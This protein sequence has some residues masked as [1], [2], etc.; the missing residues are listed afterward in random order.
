MRNLFVI[1]LLCPFVA[2]AQVGYRA[3]ILV[4]SSDEE[5]L[6]KVGAYLSN[7]TIPLE[8]RNVKTCSPNKLTTLAFGLE[9][10][11]FSKSNVNVVFDVK[12]FKPDGSILF[13]V[14]N[15]TK[16]RALIPS[17]QLAMGGDKMDLALEDSDLE[18][19]YVIQ[20]L[21]KDLIS[22]RNAQTQEKITYNKNGASKSLTGASANTFKADQDFAIWMTTYYLHP[23]PELV[24]DSINYF[25]NS[26][27]A[28]SNSH[29]PTCCFWA[30]LFRKDSALMKKCFEYFDSNGN[31]RTRSLFVEILALTMT[32]ESKQLT[33]EA[34]KK[35]FSNEL[36]AVEKAI[37]DMMI[38]SSPLEI[39]DQL[40]VGSRDE[41]CLWA[42]FFATG[43]QEIIKKFISV[44]HLAKD[45]HGM[46][47]VV[48]AAAEWSLTSNAV[49]HE[50]VLAICKDE[51]KSTQGI[52]HDKLSAIIAKAMEE[53]QKYWQTQKK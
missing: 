6:S 22:G 47:L 37:S 52:T 9:S 31:D 32:P 25:S 17:S 34:K 2:F 5:I 21:A 44:L 40:R 11:T 53:R 15:H 23:K 45:G 46:Q 43:D 7:P 42:E 8:Q 38:P 33:M 18:G 35:W 19:T 14:P 12:I 29:I 20:V 3:H 28:F 4:G 51:L 41:D 13:D 50:K 49:Q 1:L 39:R 30:A 27:I 24:Q 26:K 10:P 16:A 48:G 36:P